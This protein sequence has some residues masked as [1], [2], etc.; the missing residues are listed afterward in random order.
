MLTYQ[1]TKP[2]SRLYQDQYGYWT[3]EYY[4][5]YTTRTGNQIHKQWIDAFDELVDIWPESE[6]VLIAEY[7]N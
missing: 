4:D 7:D 3:W 1:T 6:C 5:G 2:Y